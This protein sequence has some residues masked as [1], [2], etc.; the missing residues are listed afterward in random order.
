MYRNNWYIWG[1]TQA[2][3]ISAAAELIG[4]WDEKT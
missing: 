4:Y 1:I 2:V 3:E